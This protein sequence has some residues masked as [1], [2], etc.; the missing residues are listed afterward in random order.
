MAAR[1]RDGSSGAQV[2]VVRRNLMFFATVSKPHAGIGV[3]ISRIPFDW[4]LD[5]S[6]AY[7]TGY[8]L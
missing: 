4:L 3:Y 5:N 6:E 1:S 8:E 2:N 7:S